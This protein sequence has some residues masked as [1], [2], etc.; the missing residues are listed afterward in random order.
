MP[1]IRRADAPA[2]FVGHRHVPDVT[3]GHA[4]LAEVTEQW[5]RTPWPPEFRSFSGYLSV[6]EDTVLTYARATAAADYRAFVHSLT[7]AARSEAVEYRVQR[8]LVTT[9]TGDPGCMIV[10]MFDV[11]GPDR[12]RAII[13]SL[14]ATLEA[15][16]TPPGMLSANFHASLDGTRVLNYAEWVSDEAH[17]EFLAG[18]T[19]QATLRTSTGL[20]GVR[21]IGFRRYHLFRTLTAEP[22][23]APRSRP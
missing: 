8:S 10:A 21:P 20:P 2:V 3:H 7:G 16:A 14:I 23:S 18:S 19:R 17:I 15:G 12:Q 22:V 4:L 6:E 13:D 11:D 5:Q 1:R 9:E